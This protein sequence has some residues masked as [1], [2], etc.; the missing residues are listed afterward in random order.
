MLKEAEE[1]DRN[2][3][4][5][6]PGKSDRKLTLAES[7]G[8]LRCLESCSRGRSRR[9]E[10]PLQDFDFE[11]KRLSGVTQDVRQSRDIQFQLWI[12]LR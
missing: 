10:I 5:K 3:G 9:G 7:A 4:A 12:P 2:G 11:E 6:Q 1:S 8:L